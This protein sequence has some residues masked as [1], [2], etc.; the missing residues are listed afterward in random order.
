M[1]K[2]ID[3]RGVTGSGTQP[4]FRQWACLCLTCWLELRAR[5]AARGW[6]FCGYSCK[7]ALSFLQISYK[8]GK[9]LW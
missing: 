7:E 6:S 5:V 9:V 1:C 2:K 8:I 3:F 4:Q